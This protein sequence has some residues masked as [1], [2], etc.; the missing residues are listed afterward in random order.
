MK[1]MNLPDKYSGENSK[2]VILPIEYENSL[3][4]GKGTINGSKEIIKASQNL[5]YYE[6]QFDNEPYLKGI[7]LLPTLELNDSTPENMIEK[8][9][10]EIS[11]QKN[12]FI[13]S[14][15]GDH[16]TTI[17]TIKGLESN[18]KDFSVIIFDAHSDFRDSW[19]NSSLNHAC[20]SKQISKKH[21]LSIIGV[22]SQDIDEK[23]QI[24]NSSNVHIIKSYDF[25]LDGLKE[26]LPKL[27]DKVFISMD[28]DVFDP[29][30]I[31]NTGTPEPEGLSW[32]HLIQSL[33]EIAKNK[34][35]IGVDIVEFSPKNN[36]QSEAYA[37]SRLIYKA[38][39]L[40]NR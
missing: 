20:V 27:K 35:I 39:A 29:S 5:E 21:S 15:G 6:D 9:S 24:E 2:F 36:F 7:K 19:N 16:S 30:F 26:V 8:V 10:D 11:K 33:Q 31:R 3:T 12:K 23:E 18:H 25:N 32:N 4:Y 28:V 13:I 22:R 17:G 40:N 38:M 1:W 14:L 34:E 37:L